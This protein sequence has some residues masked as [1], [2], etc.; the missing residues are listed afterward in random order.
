MTHRSGSA[1]QP[2]RTPSHF[3][4]VFSDIPAG[5]GSIMTEAFP[6]NFDGL[7][8][9]LFDDLVVQASRG[10]AEVEEAI[11]AAGR[12]LLKQLFQG[13]RPAS[14]LTHVARRCVLCAAK[15]ADS[16]DR[17]PFAAPKEGRVVGRRLQRGAGR[18]LYFLA[19]G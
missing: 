12:G 5:S 17:G 7:P 4:A 15:G 16:A 11:R 3:L 9:R 13:A 19:R 14:R 10:H 1:A 8:R 6:R 18:L 2:L